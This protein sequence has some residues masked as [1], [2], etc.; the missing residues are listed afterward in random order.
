MLPSQYHYIKRMWTR[1]YPRSRKGI[2]STFLLFPFKLCILIIASMI[3]IAFYI[4]F[5]GTLF[6]LKCIW[7]FI[8]VLFIFFKDLFVSLY[9]IVKNNP[10][11]KSTKDNIQCELKSIEN[12]TTIQYELENIKKLATIIN[13]TC[14]F[15]EFVHSFNEL[16]NKLENLSIFEND[17][18]YVNSTPSK[19]LDRIINNKSIT[20]KEF[21][22]R[23]IK[24][25]GIDSLETKKHYSYYFSIDSIS[26][27]NSKLENI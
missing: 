9:S 20:E 22:D 6:I 19:D 21:I 1:N 3:M 10:T 25:Y 16:E 13:T 11:D 7:E 15:N 23:H 2:I 4:L 5:Y 17:N 27:F 24:K 14:D 8:K 26:Y 18:I 12:L